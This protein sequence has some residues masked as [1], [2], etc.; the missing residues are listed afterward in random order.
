MYILRITWHL[1]IFLYLYGGASCN[2]L[3]W[4]K[5]HALTASSM[6]PR[7]LLESESCF[8][9]D[10]ADLDKLFNFHGIRSQLLTYQRTLLSPYT[11]LWVT[12]TTK[13][14]CS[15]KRQDF[16]T[17]GATNN[18]NLW[19]FFSPLLSKSSNIWDAQQFFNEASRLGH[20]LG[21]Q[22]LCT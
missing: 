3:G 7:L 20:G 9:D 21:H 5:W 16:K 17:G 6:H 4:P 2:G 14:V 19:T 10:G 12:N 15:G 1:S 22:P 11:L 13:I 8:D 18:A